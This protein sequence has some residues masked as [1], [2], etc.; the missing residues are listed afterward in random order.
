[1]RDSFNHAA[2]TGP[3][4]SVSAWLCNKGIVL[5]QVKVDSKSNEIVAIPALI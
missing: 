3:V 1:L 4:H 2:G 5:G